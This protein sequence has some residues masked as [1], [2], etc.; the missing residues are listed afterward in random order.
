MATTAV[1]IEIVT[2]LSTKAFLDALLRFT[3]RRG[4]PSIIHSDNATNFQGAQRE[5]A[6]LNALVSDQT[7]QHQVQDATSSVGITWKFNPPRAPHFGGLWETTIKSIKRH[8]RRASSAQVYDF[9]QLLTLT[10]SIEGILN[11][12][13]LGRLSDDP[14]DFHYLSPGHFLIGRPMITLPIPNL[15]FTPLNRLD[16]YQWIR[17]SITDLWK[18][19]SRDY[20]YSFQRLAKWKRETPNLEIGVSV[21]LIEDNPSQTHGPWESFIRFI[22]ALTAM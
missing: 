6:Q 5:L 15:D 8:L 2:S 16:H 12:R 20:L 19:W 7:F 14:E 10:T 9:E 11:S 1:H 18:F 21:L 4:L 22:P 3:S 17:R 13:P